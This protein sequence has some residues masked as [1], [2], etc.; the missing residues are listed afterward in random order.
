MSAPQAR[1]SVA[2]SEGRDLIS[3]S[4]IALKIQLYYYFIRKRKQTLPIFRV[5]NL[6]GTK[7]PPF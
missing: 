3:G 2:Q 7:I 5:S 1:P 4:L 6:L